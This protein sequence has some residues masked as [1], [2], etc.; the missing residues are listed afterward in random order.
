M[1]STTTL[2]LKKV[3][4]LLFLICTITFNMQSQA[5]S[6]FNVAIFL[7]D[8]VEI[9]DFAGPT[10][11]FS[12]TKD[13]NV[14]TVSVDGKDILSQRLVTVKPQ[15]SI[16]KAPDPD[17]IVFPGGSS[18]ASSN[19]PKVLSWIK[20]TVAGG[21]TMMSVCTGA[22]IL[23]NAHLL[24]NLQTTTHYSS[25]TDLQKT[26]PSANVLEKTRFVDNGNVITTAGVS[27]GIDG[28]LHLVARIKGI[29][30]AKATAHYMEYDKWNPG[31][32]KIVYTN[33]YLLQGAIPSGT[34]IPYQGEVIDLV[35]K[36]QTEE[37]FEQSAVLLSKVVSWYP[38]SS[39]AYSLMHT[40]YRKIGKP[41][42]LKEEQFLKLVDEGQLETARS[43]VSKNLKK[44]P[45]WKLFNEDQM[46]LRS[47]ALLGD[48]K[49]PEALIVFQMIT[50]VY[51]DSWNAWDSLAEG[52]LGSG[53]QKEAI[54]YYKKSLELNPLN[55]NAIMILQKIQP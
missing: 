54:K 47:Y 11:V 39:E 46:N 30:T 32:G 44:F 19:D 1:M 15:Y 35:R 24:D 7:Y 29:E 9:L 27:A 55:T 6:I 3:S 45:G 13:F 33:P 31:D 23:A 53:N 4:I 51:P 52:Y 10:E 37:S 21:S 17:I 50:D 28:A 43:E 41:A 18:G 40:A 16:D 49:Y 42:P 12:A 48:K 36:L 8:G 34:P 2:L 38:N 25:L 14:Y 20:T 22:F 5:K 26:V